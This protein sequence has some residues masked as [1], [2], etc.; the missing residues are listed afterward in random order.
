[1]KISHTGNL[2]NLV[3]FVAGFN[4]DVNSFW[5]SPLFFELAGAYQSNMS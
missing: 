5:S 1:M 3:D 4:L 2:F